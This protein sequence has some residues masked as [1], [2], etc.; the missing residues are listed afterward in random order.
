MLSL[1][2]C[3]T[4]QLEDDYHTI[5]TPPAPGKNS[6]SIKLC[7]TKNKTVKHILDNAKSL[8]DFKAAAIYINYDEPYYT[9][10]ENNRLRKKKYTLTNLHTDDVIKIQKGKLYHNN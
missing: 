10:R 5:N 8:K 2:I 4:D 3:C 6:Y 9:R 1:N 7:L